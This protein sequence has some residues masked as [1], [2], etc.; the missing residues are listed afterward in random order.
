MKTQ[1]LVV[2]PLTVDPDSILAAARILHAGGLVAFPTE[3]VYGL[4][5]W[6]EDEKAIQRIFEVKGRSRHNPL[7]VH[8]LETSSARSLVRHWN[9][10]AELLARAFWPGPLTLVLPR[11]TLVRDVVSAGQGTVGVRVPDHPVALA[12]LRAVGPIAAPS[13]NRSTRISPTRAEHVLKDLDG[14]IEMVL[15]AGPTRVGIE[16]TVLDLTA[17][18]A[19]ILRPGAITR[20]QIENVLGESV[21]VLP[22][23]HHTERSA[24]SPGQM[25]VHYAPR[26]D[27]HLIDENGLHGLLADPSGHRDAVL[28]ALG[29]ELPANVRGFAEVAQLHSPVEAAK[30]IYAMLH[31]WDDRGIRSIH[32]I[33][34]PPTDDWR[35]LGDRIWRAS[36]KW[37]HA[38]STSEPP[39]S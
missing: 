34:P 5:A 4:G 8:A 37:S 33:G 16:S 26:A 25:E 1:R 36:R 39:G 15:D 14:R 18:P 12:L 28:L 24:L 2:D 31:Q 20:T 38:G 35:S 6:L 11:S 30:H 27:V 13:A 21:C 10:R 23:G 19:R 9:E 7:I 29:V 17:D 22:H 3:T 32:V